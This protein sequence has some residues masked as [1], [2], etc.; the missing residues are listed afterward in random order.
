MT[1]AGGRH[2]VTPTRR[3]LS[4]HHPDQTATLCPPSRP[5]DYSLSTI[6]TRR[7]L[8]A[9][10]PDQTATLCSPSRPD[11]YSLPTIPTRWLLSAH[12][13]VCKTLFDFFFLALSVTDS[14]L[15]LRVDFVERERYSISANFNQ[16]VSLCWNY[17]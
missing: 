10:H 4:A 16:I 13:P 12:R 5:D 11:G 8:S 17:Y 7:L 1:A 3:L 6:P 14:T 2:Y 9:H 15:C